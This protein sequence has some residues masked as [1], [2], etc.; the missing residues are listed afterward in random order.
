MNLNNTPT[1][2]PLMAD[3]FDHEPWHLPQWQEQTAAERRYHQAAEAATE[4]GTED[5]GLAPHLSYAE[6]A[7][8]VLIVTVSVSLVGALAL[9]VWS[10]FA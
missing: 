9:H 7:L 8:L 3:D 2:G 4:V 1:L 10:R 5:D 6:R